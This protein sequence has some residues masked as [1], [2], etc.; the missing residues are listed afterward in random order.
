M[1]VVLLMINTRAPNTNRI[2]AL[3]NVSYDF[4]F[5]ICKMEKFTVAILKGLSIVT[6]V[7]CIN[8]WH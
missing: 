8:S 6:E 5:L 1:A 3:W 4:S 2:L 7:L